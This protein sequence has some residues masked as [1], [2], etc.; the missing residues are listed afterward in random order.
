[1]DVSEIGTCRGYD[2]KRWVP[3]DIT[4]A[5]SVAD[6]RIY[7]YYFLRTN[8][9]VSLTYRWYLGNVLVY[10]RQD[11]HLVKGYHFSWIS[12]REGERFLAGEYRVE[13]LLGTSVLEAT[14]F[15]VEE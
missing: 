5:F 10:E 9:E 3:V 8:V 13:V 14:E 12:P 15:R 4:D 2:E 11:S 6:E 1:M 7:L